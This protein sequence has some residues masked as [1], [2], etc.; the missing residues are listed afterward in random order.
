MFE[1]EYVYV[2]WSVF[3][4][5]SKKP[6]SKFVWRESVNHEDRVSGVDSSYV[7]VFMGRL[8][9]AVTVIVW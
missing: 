3:A 5:G 1:F 6:Q 9:C 7:V 4:D 8:K 2:H